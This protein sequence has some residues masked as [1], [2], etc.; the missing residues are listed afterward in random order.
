LIIN[1]K[2]I[3]IE[4]NHGIPVKFDDTFDDLSFEEM[5]DFLAALIEKYTDWDVMI[6]RKYEVNLKKVE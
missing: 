1:S 6:L 3:K 5:N 4:H 2:Y